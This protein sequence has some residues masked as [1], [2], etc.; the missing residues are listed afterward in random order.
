MVKER[1]K[2]FPFSSLPKRREKRE[3]K[4]R[5][6]SKEKEIKENKREENYPPIVTLPIKKKEN[7]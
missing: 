1:R 7:T 4:E 2:K 3:K 5:E 6:R